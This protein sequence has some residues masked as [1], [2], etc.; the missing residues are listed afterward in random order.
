MKQS[1]FHA[2]V[3]AFIVS[4]STLAWG[5]SAEKTRR[6]GILSSS[7]SSD[8]GPT[9]QAFVDGL[10]ELG[11]EEG[12][13]L[14]LEGRFA[15]GDPVRFPELAAELVSLNVDIILASNTQAIACLEPTASMT[16]RTS[17]LHS[18]S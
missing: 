12:P 18:S 13:N 4:L 7:S 14:V 2:A 11:W 3:V 15:G 9:W 8:P 6:I 1:L 10:R 5:Q 16:A 17:S